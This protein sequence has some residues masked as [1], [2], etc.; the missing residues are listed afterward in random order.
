MVKDLSK[1]HA[2]WQTRGSSAAADT[3]RRWLAIGNYFVEVCSV[4]CE[5]Y[6]ENSEATQGPWIG[7][8]LAGNAFSLTITADILPAYEQCCTDTGPSLSEESLQFFAGLR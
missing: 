8:N 5:K 2:T 3:H 7:A 4:H 1:G 6:L